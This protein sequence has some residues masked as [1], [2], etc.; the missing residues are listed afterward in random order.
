MKLFPN[1]VRS[2]GSSLLKYRMQKVQRSNFI[3]AINHAWT[4]ARN[5]KSVYGWT[6][7]ITEINNEIKSDLNALKARARNLRYNNPV[8]AGYCFDYR[9]NVV[10]AE[11]F[12]LQP[13]VMLKNG[14]L[15]DE[16]NQ[17]IKDKFDEWCDEKYCT[18]SQRYS[19]L[20]SQYHIADQ[21]GIDGEFLVH[22]I[23]G[24]DPKVNPFGMSQEFLDPA[25]IDYNK[26]V[27]LGNGHA[28]IMGVHYDQWRRIH[29]IH[30]KRK[31]IYGEL[32]GATTRD[33]TPI[34]YS[35]LLFGIDLLHYKQGRGITPLAPAMITIMGLDM[36]ENY[37]LDNAKDVA[38]RVGFIT[39][40]LEAFETY[41]GG[42]TGA[43]NDN[44]NSD[45]SEEENTGETKSTYGKYA[46]REV[47]G[48]TWEELPAGYGVTQ[49]DAKFPHEQHNPFVRGMGRKI[50]MAIGADYTILFG[51]RENET[52]S[53]Q[54]AAELKM[55]RMW[56]IKQ[57]LMRE[58]YLIRLYN[59]WL[60]NALLTGAL[61][62]L[63]AARINEYKKHYWQGVV[64]P[65]A[66]MYKEATAFEIM[67]A[68]GWMDDIDII[69]QGGRRPEEVL[70]NISRFEKMKEN[71]GLTSEDFKNG[72]ANTGSDQ[73]ADKNNPDNSSASSGKDKSSGK[74]ART[75][76]IIGNAG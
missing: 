48:S 53:S 42:S 34:P 49:P 32:T 47:L 70:R 54:R 16:V 63:G 40:T 75:L 6:T 10:G 74:N 21:I 38:H 28:I 19:F 66:D 9:A 17:F 64:Q 60:K 31:S 36:W 58:Q 1:I 62:P 67:R 20:L 35:E 68:N 14:D 56:A 73:G 51:D 15:D 39:K 72:K 45:S 2:I 27:D 46:D 33:S 52:Y 29:E 8:V 65:W 76:S 3:A 44:F 30:L 41:T 25:D 50:A 18:M 37:S 69:T 61:S 12:D 13:Q 24:I 23:D 26:N 11:G 71:Y 55:R 22:I 57:T 4:A 43:Q 7:T 59:H 5:L